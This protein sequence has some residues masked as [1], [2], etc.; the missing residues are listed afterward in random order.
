MTNYCWLT[1]A[2][3]LATHYAQKGL[4]TYNYGLSGTGNTHIL[5]SLVRADLKHQFTPDDIIMVMWSSWSRL[6]LYTRLFST[7]KMEKQNR[8]MWCQFGNVLNAE[9]EFDS[10]YT[11]NISRTPVGDY[12]DTWWCLEDDVIKSI[13][14]IYA[15]NKMYN[16]SFQGT[17]P[18]VEGFANSTDPLINRLNRIFPD[19][20]PDY[21]T[22][23]EPDST[24][25]AEHHEFFSHVQGW[26]GHPI[27]IIALDWIN[28]HIVPR[29]DIELEPGTLN[30]I[31]TYT[32]KVLNKLPQGDFD[33]NIP[34]NR[35]VWS[36]ACH[37]VLAEHR[38]KFNLNSTLDSGFWDRTHD[39]HDDRDWR[40]SLREQMEQFTDYLR[41]R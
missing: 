17:I 16:I 11:G 5:S 28:K 10:D 22:E 31:D 29:L 36:E 4:K 15:A 39:K 25:S 14:A 32:Q 37:S 13:N 38:Q 2:D 26:D 34:D 35:A 19:N 40:V 21:V 9:V 7:I 27:P 12:V 33:S 20:I 1:W 3:I 8:P 24:K 23:V 41:D 18:A 6:D 30:A